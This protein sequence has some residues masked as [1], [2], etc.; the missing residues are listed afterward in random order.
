MSEKLTGDVLP[1]TTGPSIVSP[2]P[3]EGEFG[4]DD[5]GPDAYQAGARVLAEMLGHGSYAEIA[6]A[7]YEAVRDA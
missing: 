2:R 5:P 4:W 7:V 3:C 1:V 6:K